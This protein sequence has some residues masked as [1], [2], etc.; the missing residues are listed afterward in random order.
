[1]KK[2]KKIDAYAFSEKT[3]GFTKFAQPCTNTSIV[4]WN[5]E[6]TSASTTLEFLNNGLLFISD[7][8]R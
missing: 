5:C 3:L 8:L 4:C 6:L 1:M 2:R 7:N